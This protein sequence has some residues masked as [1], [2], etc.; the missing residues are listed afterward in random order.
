MSRIET[1]AEGVAIYLGDS[2]E[3]VPTLGPVDAVVTDPPYGIGHKGD[4]ARFSGGQTR[5]GRGSTHGQIKGDEAPFDPSPFL[6][7]KYHILYR[8]NRRNSFL[9]E[10]G[11]ED[12]AWIEVERPSDDDVG[13]GKQP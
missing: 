6:V 9:V 11:D 5:R 7:G 13:S 2:R 1:I 12:G 10:G 8:I 3:I 4:S